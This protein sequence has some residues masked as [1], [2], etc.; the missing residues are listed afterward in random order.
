[1]SDHYLD[2]KNVENRL[3]EEWL[4]Y[5]KI[6][7]AYDFDDT[8]YDYHQKGRSYTDVIELLRYCKKI[9]AYFM[10]FTSC[11]ESQYPK[12]TKYLT[13]NDIPF[14]TINENLPF[15]TFTGRKCYYNILLD[16]RAGLPSAYEALN[17]ASYFVRAEKY[18]QRHCL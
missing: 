16:D 5:G 11:D 8:V 4:K 14:D 17:S 1:M 9:G 3:I 7:I 12:I 2:N 15:V 6:I 13:D 18:Y 10:V